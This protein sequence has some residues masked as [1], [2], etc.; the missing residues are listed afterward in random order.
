MKLLLTASL[1]LGSAFANNEI[2]EHDLGA[3]LA[4]A[5]GQGSSRTITQID[6]AD[7]NEYGCWCYFQ[8]G[9]GAGRGKP[10]D[11]IDVLCKRL[12]DGYTCA[13][14]DAADLNQVCVPW[15]VTYNSAM[16]TGLGLGMDINGIRTECDSQN[17]SSGCAQWA[18]KI[19]GYFLQQLVLTFTHGT[20]I[21]YNLQHRNGFNTQIDCPISTGIKSEH[22]CCDEHPLRFPFKTYNGARDCCYSHT[23]N[24]NLYQCCSDGHV[25]MT[26]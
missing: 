1:F 5:A 24:T 19:E 17:P 16:G 13:I 3:L 7:I 22:A 26:C 11:E 2:L 9:H 20:L 21:D 8:D 12:H 18:C 25:R 14:M 4:E 15:E 23:F 10:V 6:M